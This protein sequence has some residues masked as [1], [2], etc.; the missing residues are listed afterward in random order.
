MRGIYSAAYLDAL[1]RCH[2]V[3]GDGPSP[4]V[5][6]GFDLIVG[7]S[8]G[9]IVGCA[10]AQGLPLDQVVALYQEQGPR[11]FPLKVPKNSWSVLWQAGR[12][13][14]SLSRGEDALRCAL[15]SVFQS[16]TLG[17]IWSQRRIA[18][19]VP[20][21]EMARHRSWV[22]KTPHVK[23]PHINGHRDDDYSLVDICL[24]T[25]AAPIFRSLARLPSPT[26]RVHHVFADGGLWA[27]NPVLIGLIEAI[28]LT[29]PDDRIEIFCLGTCPRPPGEQ[30]D[31]K[32]VHRGLKGW[33]FGA[34]AATLSLDAQAYAFDNMARLLAPHVNRDCRIVKFPHEA[35]P[36]ELS[37]YLD[38]DETRPKA[39]EALV[40]VAET[41][42]YETWAR[43]N[44]PS[45]EE[46]KLI[47]SMLSALLC[48]ERDI[49]D[50]ASRDQLCRR[51]NGDPTVSARRT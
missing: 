32:D 16:T 27:N 3:A 5:G 41:D 34:D 35:A 11:I 28:E 50:S 23:T 4:D 49:G 9:A 22:F 39:M 42:A 7:T 36:E 33:R 43:C 37:A 31:K 6:K 13:R 25:T 40:E 19:A 26:K 44:R 45:N 29:E 24:A 14:R 46:D 21:V 15:K 47:R 10:L 18:L 2:V 12:R 20:A 48:V 38:L 1:S 17:D 30:V 8:T 51:Y